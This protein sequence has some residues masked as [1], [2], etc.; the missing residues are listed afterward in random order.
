MI[1]YLEEKKVLIKKLKIK[2]LHNFYN[3]SIKFNHDLTF[4][5]GEN[6][7]GK[8]TI[9]NIVSSIVTGKLYNLFSYK[10]DEILLYYVCET[11]KKTE[12]I[13]INRLENKFVIHLSENDCQEEIE[14]I[15][16]ISREDDE[17]ALD[18]F[19][20]SYASS[21]FLK[22]KF[23]YI[24]LPLSRNSQEGINSFENRVYAR[25]RHPIYSD[26][27]ILNKN[28][29]NDSL[30]YIEEIIKNGYMRI[31]SSEIS[32]NA[33]FRSNIFTSSLK[34]TSEYS[35][36]SMFDG[37]EKN[38]VQDIDKKKKE[39]VKLLQSIGEWNDETEKS[40]EQFFKKY[41][42]AF[43]KSQRD[44]GVTVDFLLMNMEFN[45]IKEIASQAE[46]IEK[47]KEK[48]RE[49]IT[50]FLEIV[51]NFFKATDDKKNVHINSEGRIIIESEYPR[52]SLSLYNLSSGE[53]QIIIIFACL[54]FGLPNDKNGIFIIDEP[55]ASLHLAWQKIFV[56][57]IQKVNNIQFI[58]ATHSP[59]IISKYS[60]K[61][62]K[63]HKQIDASGVLQNE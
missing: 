15:E 62:N 38:T 17:Y 39:Y 37:L 9:L 53:K 49:P 7:C 32:I 14:I 13:K 57:S 31:N 1:I 24:Y 27:D 30:H 44:R 60:K 42:N 23:N 58:F 26:K 52:R 8:T 36:S 35:A 47:E 48:L 43:Q 41:K 56:D 20:S 34:V 29:L 61:A 46:N 3:Y 11:N 22:E 40:V 50:V 25:R 21:S 63:I 2:K 6:G 5:F 16:I 18:R 4:I 28:Y 33:R 19:I 10:F 51:N 59:E 12:E 55:E 45:R 54:I